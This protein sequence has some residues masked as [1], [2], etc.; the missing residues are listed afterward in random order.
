[1]VTET[2]AKSAR[3]AGLSP[4]DAANHAE[5]NVKVVS[6]SSSSGSTSNGSKESYKIGDRVI[7]S[8]TKHGCIQFIG[9]TQFA[10]GEWAGVVLDEPIGKNDG[11]VNGIRYFQCEAKKGVFA[12]PDKL[13]YESSAT[14]GTRRSSTSGLMRPA[15]LPSAPRMGTKVASPRGNVSKDGKTPIGTSSLAK[16]DGDNTGLKVTEICKLCLCDHEERNSE[17]Y[18]F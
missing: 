12:R 17:N 4:T 3:R 10:A 8:G 11:S 14:N 2:V 5:K 16:E 1:M 18:V 15:G 6:S 7:V 13:V 9:D